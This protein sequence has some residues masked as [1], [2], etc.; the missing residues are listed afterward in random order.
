MLPGCRVQVM[1]RQ[2]HR[3]TKQPQNPIDLAVERWMDS[4]GGS[5]S[6]QEKPRRTVHTTTNLFSVYAAIYLLPVFTFVSCPVSARLSCPR[7]HSFSRIRQR[8]F[9][10]HFF[11]WSIESRRRTTHNPFSALYLTPGEVRDGREGISAYFPF[12]VL[13]SLLS[14]LPPIHGQ[15]AMARAGGFRSIV[16]RST[17]NTP[18]QTRSPTCLPICRSLQATQQPCL[19]RPDSSCYFHQLLPPPARWICRR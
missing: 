9:S 8:L 10:H 18:Q 13:S 6:R 15:A 2:R 7:S 17:I 5:V 11:A 14:F 12:R 3:R 1:S 4:A 19:L 16:G